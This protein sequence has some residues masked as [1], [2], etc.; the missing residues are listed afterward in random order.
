MC[1]R[2]AFPILVKPKSHYK[3][4]MWHLCDPLRFQWY[5]GQNADVHNHP[6]SVGLNSPTGLACRKVTLCSGI[7]V[8]GWILHVWLRTLALP[9]TWLM[10]ETHLLPL[11]GSTDDLNSLFLPGKAQNSLF[12]MLI[13]YQKQNNQSILWWRQAIHSSGCCQFYPCIKPDL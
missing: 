6:L 8:L 7:I 1:A 3:A 10:K 4:P 9:T 11:I 2:K 12:P 5:I 13:S